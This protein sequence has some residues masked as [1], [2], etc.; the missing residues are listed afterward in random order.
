VESDIGAF[1]ITN[2]FKPERCKYI[3]GRKVDMDALRALFEENQARLSQSLM[4]FKIVT[5][6]S[7]AGRYI[8]NVFRR[9]QFRDEE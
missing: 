1:E 7:I 4:S 9:E 6:T 5:S 8:P 2:V 3:E